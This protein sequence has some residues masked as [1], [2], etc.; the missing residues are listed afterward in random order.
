MKQL[1]V[2][3]V[4]EDPDVLAFD[5]WLSRLNVSAESGTVTVL[6]ES[7]PDL[8][9]LE[10]YNMTHAHTVSADPKSHLAYFP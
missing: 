3:Q 4:G 9:E 10:Q 5:P 8:Q 2:H 6:R 7:N 1:S